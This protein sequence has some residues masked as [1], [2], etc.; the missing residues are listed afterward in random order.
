MKVEKDEFLTDGG[1]SADNRLIGILFPV[2]ISRAL[3]NCPNP[4]STRCVTYDDDDDES[5]RQT[6][7]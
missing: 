5:G 3:G 4:S 7:R 2:S 6:H 1:K